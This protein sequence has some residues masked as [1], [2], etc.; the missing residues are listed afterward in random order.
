MQANPHPPSRTVQG[1][2]HL[3]LATHGHIV[4]P[5]ILRRMGFNPSHLFW[6]SCYLWRMPRRWKHLGPWKKI[7]RSFSCMCLLRL[8]GELC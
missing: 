5:R 1:T 3:A 7:Q 2:D 8:L 4:G 6:F